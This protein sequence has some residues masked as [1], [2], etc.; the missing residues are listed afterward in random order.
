MYCVNYERINIGIILLYVYSCTVHRHVISKSTKPK[1]EMQTLPTP[2][3]SCFYF[4]SS[5]CELNQQR[6]DK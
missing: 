3:V 6:N 4:Y 5:A 1:R 2:I